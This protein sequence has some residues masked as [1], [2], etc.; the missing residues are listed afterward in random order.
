MD[1]LPAMYPKKL[2]C[3]PAS[4]RTFQDTLPV[5]SIDFKM[6]SSG[7]NSPGDVFMCLLSMYEH[8][9]FMIREADFTHF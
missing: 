4:A 5:G 1:H 8:F 7:A 3:R 6:M 2:F 9:T